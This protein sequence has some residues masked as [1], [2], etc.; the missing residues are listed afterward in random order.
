[1]AFLFVRP[2]GR[3]YAEKNEDNNTSS[4]SIGTVGLL[5]RVF[6]QENGFGRAAH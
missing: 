6:F 4:N 2:A 3:V 5:L 1:M